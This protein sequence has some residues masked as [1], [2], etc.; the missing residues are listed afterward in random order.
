MAISN[1]DKKLVRKVSAILKEFNHPQN[2]IELH[3]TARSALDAARSLN[4]PVGA[5]VK[6]LVFI[7]KSD[8]KEIPVVALI[9]GDKQC[10]AELLPTILN[11]E[12][13]VVRPDAKTVKNITG[14][15]IGGVSPLGLSQKLD[16]IIDT[17]LKKFDEIWS[18]AGHTH[19]VFGST[20]SQLIIMTNAKESDQITSNNY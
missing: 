17:S 9:S 5:I 3:E 13:S 11:I 4:V 6:T 18:A 10:D 15:S 20:Y 16:L 8:K 19:C 14:Y 2:V 1:L 7:I 12:G